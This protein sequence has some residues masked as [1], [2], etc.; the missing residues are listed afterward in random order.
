M[1]D[2]IIIDADTAGMT[3]AII[4]VRSGK[5]VLILEDKMCVR[6]LTTSVAV[7]AK[8]LFDT[9]EYTTLRNGG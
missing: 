1:Y 9:C 8:A 2:I 3:V 6:Q 5:S 4:G 7:L